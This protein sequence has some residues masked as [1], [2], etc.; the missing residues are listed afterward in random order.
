MEA[1]VVEVLC[2]VALFGFTS[3]G[4]ASAP[5]CFVC[6]AAGAFA[7]SRLSVVVGVGMRARGVAASMT[8]VGE[9][10]LRVLRGRARAS[11]NRAALFAGFAACGVAL[12]AAGSFLIV[13]LGELCGSRDDEKVVGK[14]SFVS[15]FW[16]PGWL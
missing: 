11:C 1:V 8:V 2:S 16:R 3:R 7:A 10:V 12:P 5:F 6:W 13:L 14:L 15:F 9:V 4:F